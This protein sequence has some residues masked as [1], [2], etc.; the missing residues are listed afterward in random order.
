MIEIKKIKIVHFNRSEHHQRMV[1]LPCG[2]TPAVG[3]ILHLSDC[4][5]EETADK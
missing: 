1:W 2:V 5:N 3:L 4:F